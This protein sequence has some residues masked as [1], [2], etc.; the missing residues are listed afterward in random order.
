[1]VALIAGINPLKSFENGLRAKIVKWRDVN[2]II[3]E[4]FCNLSIHTYKHTEFKFFYLA[5]L[6]L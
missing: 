4:Y 1:M 2:V 6:E 3:V 5:D